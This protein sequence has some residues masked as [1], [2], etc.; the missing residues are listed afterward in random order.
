[1]DFPGDP[2]V[3]ILHLQCRGHGSDLG[4]GTKILIMANKKEDAIWEDLDDSDNALS[5][6]AGWSYIHVYFIYYS[7]KYTHIQY[8][9]F[10]M[11]IFHNFK[12]MGK[13]RNIS[14]YF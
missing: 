7:L 13:R 5:S 10:C 8:I 4:C 1:M 14:H 3:K 12:E 11:Y 6:Y 2:V 9:F